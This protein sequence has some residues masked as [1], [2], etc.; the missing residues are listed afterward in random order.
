MR[1]DV[2]AYMEI[3]TMDHLV[4]LLDAIAKS[5]LLEEKDK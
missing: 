5:G 1:T 4:G 3:V 2:K